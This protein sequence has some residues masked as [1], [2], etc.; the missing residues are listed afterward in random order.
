MSLILTP[1]VGLPLIQPG[2]NLARLI[3]ANIQDNALLV[4]ENDIF[5]IT[6][7][8]ISKYE[9]RFIDLNEVT[10]SEKALVLGKITSKDP[11][12]VEVILSESA[13]ILRAVPGTLIVEHRLG[14]VCANAGVDHSNIESSDRSQVLL[15]PRDPSESARQIRA[16]ICEQF[17]AQIGV[18]VVDTHGRAWRNGAVGM[19]IGGSGIPMLSDQRGWKDL[20]GSELRVTQVAIADELAGA[21]SLLMGQS[22]EGIPV[23]KVSGFPYPLIEQPFSVLIRDRSKD[24]FR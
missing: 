8:V 20:Y 1:L 6:Q 24:L 23:V 21:A 5:V 14:F 16:F 10:P 9:N 15:L 17:N 22:N 3:V 13:E 11:R 18:L 7:K 4:Q 19:A 2:D 12:V